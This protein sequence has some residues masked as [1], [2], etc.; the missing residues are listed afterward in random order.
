MSKTI[1][2]T[3]KDFIQ[4]LSPT[5]NT[6]NK[7]GGVFAATNSIDV[8]RFP[9]QIC[10]G[11]AGTTMPSDAGPIPETVYNLK[12][13]DGGTMGGFMLG[14][15]HL[16]RILSGRIQA[17]PH[18]FS[19]ASASLAHGIIR[20]RTPADG[21]GVFY[22]TDTD[23]GFW[24]KVANTYTDNWGSTIPTGAGTLNTGYVH[25]TA[26]LLDIIYNTNA[27]FSNGNMTIGTYDFTTGANGTLNLTRF[28]LP[29]GCYATDIK[30]VNGK[31]EI[32]ITNGYRASVII[33]DGTSI[34][35][36]SITD[37]DDTTILAATTGDGVPYLITSGNTSG[38]SI[39]QKDYYGYSQV[40]NIQEFGTNTTITPSHVVAAN[41]QLFIGD[42]ARSYIY[43]YG[44]PYGDYSY[45]GTE[46]T[47][48]FPAIFQNF[49]KTPGNVRCMDIFTGSLTVVCANGSGST[50]QTYPLTGYTTYNNSGSFFQTNFIDLPDDAVIE[51][52][53]FYVQP[54][55]GTY[56]FTPSL[57]T[58]MQG[59]AATWTAPSDVK[60]G[61]M[62]ANG[63][64][65]T[66]YDLG[67]FADNFALSGAWPNCP[68]S[69]GTI[70]THRID[71]VYT[72]PSS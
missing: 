14:A 3:A 22:F 57:F 20:G 12:Y 69:N 21:D 42:A 29:T 27:S 72:S 1:T 8:F 15:S 24:A 63:N 45:R 46:N 66:Y 50:V 23:F 67:I 16:Y 52:L 68:D 31:I 17:S 51:Q 70:I 48:T 28:Q 54:P 38:I 34:L 56:A 59:G 18:A 5:Q 26:T 33:W 25:R 13:I 71:V 2:L 9:G 19:G 6:N 64:S 61:N 32:Y 35:P 65:K 44:T 4:G 43:S 62:D 11:P 10:P 30:A 40:Q 55:T 53:V 36:D 7:I 60:L 39:R 49:I 41:A 37:I 58:D 47:G